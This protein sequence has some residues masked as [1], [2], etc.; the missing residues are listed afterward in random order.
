[1]CYAIRSSESIEMGY[2]WEILKTIIFYICYCIA[3]VEDLF[4]IV[5]QHVEIFGWKPNW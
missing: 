1:M 3:A 4:K 5:W 2:I